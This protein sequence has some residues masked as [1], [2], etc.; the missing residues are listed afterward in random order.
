MRRVESRHFIDVSSGALGSG[1]SPIDPEEAAARPRTCSFCD[2]VRI[3]YDSLLE[4]FLCS[5][6]LSAAFAK[7]APSSLEQRVVSWEALSACSDLTAGQL[8]FGDT[9]EVYSEG[10]CG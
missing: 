1:Q 3:V 5:G 7:S 4:G 2:A 9:E 6:F 8:G 10:R